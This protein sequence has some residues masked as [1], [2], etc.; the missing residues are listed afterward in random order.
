MLKTKSGVTIDISKS[1]EIAAGGEGKI[2]EHP[3]D[4]KKVIKIYHQPRKAEFAKHLESL[5]SLSSTFIKPEEIYFDTNGKTLGFSMAYVNFN[6]YFLFNNLFNKGFCTSNG[7][8]KDFK[9]KLLE[10][11]KKSLEELHA[12]DIIVGDLNMY[13]IF[14]S[15]KGELIF[16]DVDSYQTKTQPHSGVLL[17][18]IR[19]WTTPAITKETDIWAYDILSFWTLSYMHPFKWVA[20][21]NKD[22][23]EQRVRQGKSILT[24]IPNIKIPALYEAPNGEI[25]KQ[26]RDIFGGRRYFVSFNN[27]HVA[28]S[29]V[30]SRAVSSLSLQIRELFEHVTEVNVGGDFIAVKIQGNWQYVE[31]KIPRVDRVLTSAIKYE[32]VFPNGTEKVFF[33]DNKLI[34]GKNEYTFIQPEFFYYNGFLTVIDYGTDV[35][36]NFNLNNQLGGIDH[37]Q[38]PVFAK[39]IVIRDT[40]IQNFGGKKFL[41]IPNNNSYTL[42]EVPLGTKN[43]IYNNGFYAVEYT[44]NNQ[45][46]FRLNF[47]KNIGMDLDYLPYFTTKG[48]NLLIPEDGYISVVANF[49]EIT[50]L[51]ASMCTRTSKLYNCNSGILLL[52][53]NILYL[54]NTK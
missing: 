6:D 16:V 49:V 45:I 34:A 19:D 54:L 3:K 30:V 14:F 51:D 5:S 31:T 12:I 25:E 29:A 43:A 48:A 10:K 18:E 35:Q 42:I 38:T 44:E 40:P 15:S 39:S 24:K 27:V 47:S 13:N 36:Y 26:F 21:G 33:Q 7:I 50:R 22:T 1:K 52:E 41:N 11:F 9:I 8:N 4:K 37:R 28:T 17:D 23:L 2:V 32:A 20:P 46:K 53:N